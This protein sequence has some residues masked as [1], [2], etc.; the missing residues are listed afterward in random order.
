MYTPFNLQKKLKGYWLLFLS[1][2]LIR[3]TLLL[4]V[5]CISVNRATLFEAN[6]KMTSI[7]SIQSILQSLKAMDEKAFSAAVA[8]VQAPSVH[9]MV[10]VKVK[11]ASAP[12]APS[13]SS[14]PA[15]EDKEEAKAPRVQSL[16]QKAWTAFVK[17]QGATEPFKTWKSQQVEQ[18]GNLAMVYAKTIKDASP[19]DYKSWTEAWLLRNQE[20]PASVPAP[21]PSAPAPP[22]P[23]AASV[24]SE[25][26]SEKKKRG[27]APGFHVSEETKAK[28]KATR[29]AK[30]T[31][32]VSSAV[33]A[34]AEPL[35]ASD[36][37]EEKEYEQIEVDGQTLFWDKESGA[38]FATND[39]EVGEQTGTFDGIAFKS[40]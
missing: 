15:A 22:S 14:A 36:D 33:A 16:T 10:K 37:E 25:T 13:A 32:K 35:P 6:A 17:E 24:G 27:R 23:P 39:G 21:S 2:H 4:S 26:S 12:S 34:A 11:V 3:A 31:A 40:I 9:K 20:A 38:C 30:K 29:E 19:E 5:P 7:Q 28:A 8:A 18:K 1:T